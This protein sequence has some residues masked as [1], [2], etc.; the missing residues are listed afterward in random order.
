[1]SHLA[2]V[3]PA[4]RLLPSEHELLAPIRFCGYC[5]VHA[6]AQVEPGQRICGDC[7]LGVL[8]STSLAVAPKPGEPALVIDRTLTVCAVN[9]HAED[10]LGVDEPQAINAHIGRFLVPAHAEAPS[11]D[12]LVGQVVSAAAGVG[13]T[14]RAVVRPTGE[15]GIR[16]AV[17]IGACGPPSAALIVLDDDEV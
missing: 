10:L 14:E 8:L 9:R 16:Y 5:G 11:L 15:F 17:R 12:G 7:G 1:M 4:L 3:R 2:V 6:P 13:M